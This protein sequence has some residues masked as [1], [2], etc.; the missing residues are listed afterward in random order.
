MDQE[1]CVPTTATA[2]GAGASLPAGGEGNT[3]GRRQLAGSEQAIE[4]TSVWKS[5]PELVQGW[6]PALDLGTHGVSR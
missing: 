4:G 3:A 5:S 2:E 1:T 6:V